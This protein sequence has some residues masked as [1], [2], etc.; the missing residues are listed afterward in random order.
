VK[1][2]VVKLSHE[3]GER[4]DTLIHVSKH[5]A[6]QLVAY[7]RTRVA[8]PLAPPADWRRENALA[9]RCG[10]CRN[11]ARFLDDPVQKI[12]MFRAIETAMSRRPS[13]GP[14]ATLTRL[15]QLDL[16]SGNLAARWRR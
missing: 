12:W 10:H 14:A 2:Y 3:E 7:L 5:P 1:R 11:L 6:R 15:S 13:A 16:V 4:L 8:L 9:C